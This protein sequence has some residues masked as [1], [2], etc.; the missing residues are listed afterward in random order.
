MCKI[1]VKLNSFHQLIELKEAV[2][3][4]IM[5]VI[6]ASISLIN[7]LP[8]NKYCTDNTTASSDSACDAYL[9][10]CKF[11]GTGYD[12]IWHVSNILHNNSAI[13]T[14]TEILVYG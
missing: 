11:T 8:T 10:G 7:L 3:Y 1:F 14:T 6:D 5:K 4:I 2:G 9:C 12:Q 13:K